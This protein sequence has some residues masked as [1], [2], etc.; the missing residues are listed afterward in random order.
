LRAFPL[1]PVGRDRYVPVVREAAP[2]VDD[3]ETSEETDASIEVLEQTIVDLADLINRLEDDPTVDP[4]TVA[5]MRR[6]ERMQSN[7]L[8]VI[9]GVRPPTIGAPVVASAQEPPTGS[10]GNRPVS[11]ERRRDIGGAY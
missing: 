10:R 11:N 8:A 5:A 7:L 6:Q 4:Q 2:D 3:G 9:R 1:F